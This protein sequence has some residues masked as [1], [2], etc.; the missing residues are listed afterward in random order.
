[1]KQYQIRRKDTGKVVGKTYYS[2]QVQTLWLDLSW[3][4]NTECEIVTVV[5]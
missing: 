3:V 2:W 5:L 1:M 4:L